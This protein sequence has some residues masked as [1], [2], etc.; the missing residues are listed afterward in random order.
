MEVPDCDEATRGFDS[1]PLNGREVI[2]N[3]D[4][5]RWCEIAVDLCCSFDVG[6]PEGGTVADFC[7]LET[8]V[9]PEFFS[10]LS[11]TGI[12]RKSPDLALIISVG[13]ESALDCRGLM[14]SGDFVRTG[15][16]TV[17]VEAGD[18]DFEESINDGFGIAIFAKFAS[19]FALL[20]VRWSFSP[21]WT[22]KFASLPLMFVGLNILERDGGASV[23]ESKGFPVIG[24]LLKLRSIS[25]L[26]DEAKLLWEMLL[27]GRRGCLR[28]ARGAS[29]SEESLSELVS[30]VS[31]SPPT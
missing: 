18:I 10:V 30:E 20:M 2:V 23:G 13:D 25:G 11:F 7:G 27:L 15:G 19:L 22:V 4:E 1:R 31:L 21:A 16:I 6:A 12:G 8:T 17:S 24:L 9:K 14:G 3:E 29:S 26:R 28:E 5:W